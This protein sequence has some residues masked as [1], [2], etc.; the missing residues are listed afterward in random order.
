[1]ANLGYLLRPSLNKNHLYFQADDDIWQV[2]IN[3]DSVFRAMR[4]TAGKAPSTH[5]HVCPE[6]KTLAY[7]GQESGEPGIY[8]M[9]TEG[10]TPKRISHMDGVQIVGWQDAQTLILSSTEESPFGRRPFLYHF[11][12][13]Q[14]TTT[15]LPYGPATRMD[16]DEWGNI[17][18]GRNCGDPAYWKRYRGGTAQ[19]VYLYNLAPQ[20]VYGSKRP[21]EKTSNKSSKT[22]KRT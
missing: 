22:W 1:M 10:G 12:L 14:E 5:P 19:E 21:S 11:D 2:S 17:V 9:P 8:L 16:S 13:K 20:E 4:L 6:G 18:L 15:P 7:R 3:G